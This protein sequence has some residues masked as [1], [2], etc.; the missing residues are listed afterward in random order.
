[1]QPKACLQPLK[2][3]CFA[4][5]LLPTLSPAGSMERSGSVPSGIL[6]MASGPLPSLKEEDFEVRAKHPGSKIRGCQ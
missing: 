1:M 3:S 2:T 4:A 5:G 6:P